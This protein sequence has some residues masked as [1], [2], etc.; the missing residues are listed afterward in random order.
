MMVVVPSGET[1][2]LL[3]P[4]LV[5][6]LRENPGLAAVGL[7]AGAPAGELPGELPADLR[8]L[9]ALSNGLD[10][11]VRASVHPAG[12]TLSYQSP[13]TLAEAAG[14]PN[15][16]DYLTIGTVF[17]DPLLFDTTDGSIWVARAEG[18][19]WYQECSLERIAGS[20]DE[21]MAEWVAAPRFQELVAFG[22]D[23][24][25]DRDDWWRLLQAAG[26]VPA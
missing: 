6:A 16:E 24:D 9:L 19:Y 22:D 7:R 14:I 8:R 13:E 25:R 20:L 11:G 17:E 18:G 4:R 15:A 12:E 23:E 1:M 10:L 3:V 21:F 5:R 26:R 2:E